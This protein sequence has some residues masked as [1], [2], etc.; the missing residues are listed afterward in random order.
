MNL[1]LGEVLLVLMFLDKRVRRAFNDAV[2]WLTR[3]G[4]F[5]VLMW[6]M[7]LFIGYGALQL[8]LGVRAGYPV[9]EAAKSFAF[10]YYVVLIITGLVVGVA[11]PRFIEHL[12]YVVPR[13]NPIVVFVLLPLR[14]FFPIPI[15]ATPEITAGAASAL[16]IAL[17]LTYHRPG[18]MRSL[19]IGVNTVALLY[20]QVRGD[21]LGVVLAVLLWAF[22]D[23]RWKALAAAGLAGLVLAGVVAAADIRI[24]GAPERGGAVTPDEVFARAV[25][26]VDPE[27]AARFSDEA[28]FF[29]G[30][31]AWRQNWWDEIWASV[32]VDESHALFGHGYGYPLAG[33]ADFLE[34][35]E[36]PLRTPHSIFFYTLGYTGWLGVAVF[37][38]FHLVVLRLLFL[39]R[40][41]TGNPFGPMLWV[42]GTTA[43]LFGNFFETPY[44]AVPFW[45]L[46]GVVLASLLREKTSPG[47]AAD[48]GS[49]YSQGPT[50]AVTAR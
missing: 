31:A 29:E 6:S 5:H 22:L 44:N 17:L 37:G 25:A 8:V 10:H 7:V 48:D 47:D 34:G 38:L 41:L 39:V 33:L 49:V 9:L 35:A 27:L 19:L 50:D 16:S 43:A 14:G 21:W 46:V 2:S 3:P 26:P 28:A 18:H 24:P 11:M 40:R 20:L 32:H 30:T 13:V 4:P 42:L 45:F 12:A 15:S 1:F 23:R 36:A